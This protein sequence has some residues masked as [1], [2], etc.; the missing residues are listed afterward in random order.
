MAAGFDID[1]AVIMGRHATE[2]ISFPGD[3]FIG[4]GNEC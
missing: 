3:N 4:E 2:E 1:Q